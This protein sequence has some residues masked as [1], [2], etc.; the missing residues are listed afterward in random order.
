MAK[1]DIDEEII[2]NAWYTYLTTGNMP[3]S[4]H[5]PW[6][7]R[8]S[9]RPFIKR[10]PRS[11]RCRICY[12]PFDGIGGY[13]TRTL[14]GVEPSALH[15]HLCNLCERF[16]T[17]YHG[18]VEIEISIMFVD[19]R[20]S[21]TMAET[22]SAEQFSKKINGFY[23]AATEVFYKHNGLV[24][25]LIGDEVAGFFVPGFAGPNHAHAAVQA[26]NDVLR[27][28]GYGSSSGPW[29][30]VGVGIHTG[31]AYVGSVSAEGG[32]SNISIL[33]D[34]VNTAARLTSLAAP[35]ELLMSEETRLAAGWEIGTMESRCLSLK[36]KSKTVD[37]WALR[38]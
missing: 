18:G 35:G 34:A 7:E 15:P 17:K 33:G 20:G 1:S 29:I 23:R 27:V 4:L 19:V 21:T 3:R 36:G 10:I 30:P 22:S 5:A 31:A 8:K 25:K 38:I 24:E 6:F 28:M 32:V 13:L 12:L 11:P 16:A 26:G 14:L 2:R 9:L 37:A